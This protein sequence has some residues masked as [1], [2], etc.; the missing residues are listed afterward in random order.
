MKL[1][2]LGGVL[3]GVRSSGLYHFGV[4]QFLFTGKW[5]A[6]VRGYHK[7]GAGWDEKDPAK[8]EQSKP[9]TPGHLGFEFQLT[10]HHFHDSGQFKL[11]K[12]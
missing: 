1:T 2:V 3:L 7:H 11:C 9:R 5:K 12:S 8:I 10:P 6:G 4:H